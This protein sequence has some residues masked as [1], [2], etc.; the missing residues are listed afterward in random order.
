MRLYQVVNHFPGMNQIC[1][2]NTLAST[3]KKLQKVKGNEDEYDFIP[4]TWVLP[5]EA[6]DLNEFVMKMKQK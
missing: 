4:R 6:F 2:K 1:R 5:N 3:L